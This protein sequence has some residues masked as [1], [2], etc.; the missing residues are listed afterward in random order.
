MTYT[1]QHQLKQQLQL[2]YLIGFF[3]RGID[4]IKNDSTKQMIVRKG[5]LAFIIYTLIHFLFFN[6]IMH[7]IT[8]ILMTF[9]AM[10]TAV[11]LIL[12]A[13]APR[14]YVSV[15]RNMRRIGLTNAADETPILLNEYVDPENPNTM[16]M[17]FETYG[18]PLDEWESKREKIESALNVSI[19]DITI[20]K[21]NRRI[22]VRYVYANTNW[23]TPVQWADS[24]IKKSEN[25][26]VLG[27]SIVGDVIVD[28][29]KIP[30]LLIGGSTGSGKTVLLKLIIRQYLAHGATVILADLKGGVD[31]PL[32]TDYCCVLTHDHVILNRL[33]FLITELERRKYLFRNESCTNINE[34]NQ[35]PDHS[36]ERIVF[37]CDEIAELFD[38][39]GASKERKD[40]LNQIEACISTIARQGRAFG[41]HLVLATQR[42]DANILPGQIKNNMDY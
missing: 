35:I 12:L 37:A 40:L 41:I 3:I 34:Y 17:E 39:T 5:I 13:G 24:M 22:L 42:P 36:M 25:L 15:T 19:A 38:K 30:H 4:R 7:N 16:I 18:I 11:F 21:D 27:R 31:F 14:H 9:A 32:R 28:I 1:E 10:L 29:S 20:G 26:L 23:M 6:D 2:R 8:Y 33:Q